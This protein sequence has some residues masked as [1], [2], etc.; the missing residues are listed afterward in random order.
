MR[1][2]NFKKGKKVFN[3]NFNAFFKSSIK[4]SKKIKNRLFCMA[5]RGK[6]G[7]QLGNIL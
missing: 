6:Q 4:D 3:K 2:H 7:K 5:I 1:K